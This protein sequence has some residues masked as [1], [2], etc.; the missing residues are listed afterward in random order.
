MQIRFTCFR[1]TILSQ[2]DPGVLEYHAEGRAREIME[3]LEPKEI[4]VKI[5][6]PVLLLQ[7]NPSQ[8]GMMTNASIEYA[9]PKLKSA[10]HV[11]IEPFGHGLG[12]DSWEAGLLLR[13]VSTFL[14][15]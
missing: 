5:N 9:L 11:L 13:A 4:L 15:S 7:G 12:L 6:C 2:L 3:G 8:G 1:A 10:T 14:E